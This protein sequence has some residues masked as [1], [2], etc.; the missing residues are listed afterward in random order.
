MTK[1]DYYEIL[2]VERGASDREIKKAYRKSALEFHPDRNPGDSAAEERFKEAAEAYEVLSDTEKRSTYD[3][4]GHEGLSKTGFSGFSGFDDVFS[5]LGDIF[6]DIFGFGGRRGPARGRD[7][8]MEISLAFEEAVFGVTQELDVPRNETCTECSGSGAKQGTK[9]VT[10]IGC[11]GR[12]EVVHRQGLLMMRTTCP[13][14]R[15]AGQVIREKC[16]ECGG[17]GLVRVTRKVDIDIPAGV[18]NGSQ[19]RLRGE[20]LQGEHGAQAGDL[21]VF[22]RVQDHAEFQRDDADIHAEMPVDFVTA[23]LGGVEKVPTLHGDERIKIPSGSQPG[24]VL[25]LR[26]KGV[27]YLKGSGTGDHYVHVKLQVPKKLSRKQKKALEQF[28]EAGD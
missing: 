7:L 27:P 11:D 6:G 10:C 14:C 12:G 2:N 21:I 23:C 15:G 20:G 17:G 19:L 9:P 28:R 22:I 24:D 1:R 16:A 8:G 13:Q 26:G 4:F 25:R 5:H 3:R 18:D